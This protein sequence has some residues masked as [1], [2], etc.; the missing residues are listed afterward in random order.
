MTLNEAIER[1]NSAGVLSPDH[2][3]REIFIHALGL[4]RYMP[5]DKTKDFSSDLL[6]SLIE[7]RAMREPLAYIL[8]KCWFYNEEY[9]VDERVLVPRPDTEIL[10]DYAVKHLPIG[11]E[12]L[13]LCTGSGCVAIS[14]LAGT[15]STRCTAVDISDG[16]LTLARSNAEK[17]GVLDRL[18]LLRADVMNDELPKKSVHAVLSNPPY[19][20]DSVCDTL[21]PEV[22]R[23]P[24]IALA[25]GEDGMDFYR[26]ITPIAKEI[27]DE[28]GFI[29]YEIGYDE[30]DKIREL[31]ESFG[32]CAEII[33]DY[34][35][36][37]RVAVLRKK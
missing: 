5:I 18:T 13:D 25:G 14:V 6:E 22:M 34:S 32:L 9:D 11:C 35:S 7:R 8:G 23:E 16:A 27:I 15:L 20:P 4:P 29:A 21:S 19:I 37:D 36:N 33:K 12:F 10:V 28:D 2:D 24:R 30:G 26:R 3:A 31:A 1:L 17:N